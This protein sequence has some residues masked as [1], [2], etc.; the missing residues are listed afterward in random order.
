VLGSMLT[1][2]LPISTSF[3]WKIWR[4]SLSFSEF[5]NGCNLS[6][7]R[8]FFAQNWQNYLQNHNTDLLEPI[9]WPQRIYNHNAHAVVGKSTRENILGL[10]TY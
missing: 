9:L 4:T 8:Q 7:T 2:F 1:K 10:K 5:I 3:R 6:E